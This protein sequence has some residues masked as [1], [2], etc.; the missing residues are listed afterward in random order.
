MFLGVTLPMRNLDGSVFQVPSGP[1]TISGIGNLK[2]GPG[3]SSTTTFQYHFTVKDRPSNCGVWR[4]T[5]VEPQCNEKVRAYRA[6][7]LREPQNAFDLSKQML[8]RRHPTSLNNTYVDGYFVILNFLVGCKYQA[9]FVPRILEYTFTSSL[10]I[11]PIC[12]SHLVVYSS[13]Y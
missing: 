13:V 7:V 2:R 5:N 6:K 12:S 9:R 8:I 11:Q 4:Y 10:P 3:K 1:F